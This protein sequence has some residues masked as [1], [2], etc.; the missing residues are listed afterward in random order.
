MQYPNYRDR[1]NT[2]KAEGCRCVAQEDSTLANEFILCSKGTALWWYLGTVSQWI[3]AL[4]PLWF[5]VFKCKAVPNVDKRWRTT[6]LRLL[7]GDAKTGKPFEQS[8]AQP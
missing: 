1:T 2:N 3:D 7:G 8:F 5:R 6:D 4:A